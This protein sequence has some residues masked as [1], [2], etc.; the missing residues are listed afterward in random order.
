MARAS[1]YKNQKS[2]KNID[3]LLQRNMSL[4]VIGVRPQ[5]AEYCPHAGWPKL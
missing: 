4:W 3:F 5:T 1:T 2:L